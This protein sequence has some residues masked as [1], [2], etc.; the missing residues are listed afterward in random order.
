MHY[1]TL[2]DHPSAT[3]QARPK[4]AAEKRKARFAATQAIL[5]PEQLAEQSL[6]DQT[7]SRRPI[8]Q[9]TEYAL[10]IC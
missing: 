8:V 10:V 9:V 5:S 6:Q 7:V 4:N 3:K 2:P 1:T